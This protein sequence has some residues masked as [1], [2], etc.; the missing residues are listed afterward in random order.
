MIGWSAMSLT[1]LRENATEDAL[2]KKHYGTLLAKKGRS[3]GCTIRPLSTPGGSLPLVLSVV[4]LQ[5]KG[6]VM[7]SPTGVLLPGPH[8]GACARLQ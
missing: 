8:R 4:S 6:R 1:W 2:F 5:D 7:P 3:W